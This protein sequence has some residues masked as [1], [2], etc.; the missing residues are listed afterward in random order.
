MFK[1]DIHPAEPTKIDHLQGIKELIRTGDT[2]NLEH[3]GDGKFVVGDENG[4][5]HYEGFVNIFQALHEAMRAVD[6]SIPPGLPPHCLDPAFIA[7][8]FRIP[9]RDMNWQGKTKPEPPPRPKVESPYLDGQQA[10]DYL[11]MTKKA[12]YGHVERRKLRPMPGY[13]MYRFTKEQL[14]GFLKG[15]KP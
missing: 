3:W 5:W 6:P 7:K 8:F 11:G 14:D 10:A 1:S 15:E 4:K 12:L 13:K 2:A 9:L